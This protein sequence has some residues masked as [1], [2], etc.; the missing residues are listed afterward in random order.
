[1]RR[2]I[3][4]TVGRRRPLIVA[5]V[6][7]LAAFSAGFATN[8][9]LPLRL[10]YLLF[11]GLVAA[12]LWTWLSSRGVQVV[13][14]RDAERVQVGGTL[15]EDLEIRNRSWL[16]KFWLEVEEEGTLPAHASEQVVS[17]AAQGERR[18]RLETVCTRRGLYTLGPLVVR[19]GDPFDL[20][21]RVRRFGGRDSLLVYPRPLALP[22]YTLPP[23]TL[24]GEGRVRRRTQDV[25]PNAAGVR[26]YAPGDSVNRIHWPSTLR[27][28]HLI[29][30]TF[31]LDP[32]AELWLVLDLAAAAH[33]G[34]GQEAT[35]EYGVT[36]AAS[37]AQRFL[38]EHR[39]VGM[40]SFTGELRTVAPGRTRGQLPRLLEELAL[41]QAEGDVPVAALLRQQ[42]RRWGR[43]TTVVLITPAH[44]VPTQEAVLGLAGSGV[45][46]AVILLDA[47]GFGGGAGAAEAAAQ[48]RAAGVQTNLVRRGDFLPEALDAAHGAPGRATAGVRA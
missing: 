16:P 34:E 30:K 36:A 27:A 38:A 28:G 25:T 13:V 14:R 40:L 48:L 9:W 18:W 33:A 12:A 10:G 6:L 45:Q 7:V 19:S 24:A 47:S 29:V 37:V 8:F 4:G 41:A 15:G 11:F 39:A 23:A 26:E 44:D 22:R 46:T 43:Q 35:I 17:L 32:A 5:T 1:M 31:E 20:F 3:G 2:F 42:A 21:R